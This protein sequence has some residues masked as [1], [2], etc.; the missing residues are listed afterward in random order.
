M[1]S[2]W[3]EELLPPRLRGQLMKFTLQAL[4]TKV[5][6]YIVSTLWAISPVVIKRQ[7]NITLSH[8]HTH[9][10]PL[11]F[12]VSALEKDST[13]YV[14]VSWPSTVAQLSGCSGCILLKHSC[15]IF[16]LKVNTKM[17]SR[18]IE[19]RTLLQ[20]ITGLL[21]VF[22]IKHAFASDCTLSLDYTQIP[23]RFLQLSVFF[24]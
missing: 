2:S 20:N 19:C 16:N 12:I 17:V 14:F 11:L 13:V 1:S 4:R 10:S 21:I 18:T 8:A 23:N 6:F 15:K 9:T 22:H 3:K 5:M 24:V 7:L